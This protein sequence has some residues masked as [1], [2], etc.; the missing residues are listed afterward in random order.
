MQELYKLVGRPFKEGLLDSIAE[1]DIQKKIGLRFGLGSGL[2]SDIQ[3]QDHS[4]RDVTETDDAF[5]L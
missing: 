2:F 5:P 3:L 4:N 1:N